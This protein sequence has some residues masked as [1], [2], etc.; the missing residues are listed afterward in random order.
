MNSSNMISIQAKNPGR[1]NFGKRVS[2][3]MDSVIG[4]RKEQQ[5]FAGMVVEDGQVLAVVC[6]GMGGLDGGS[7]ASSSAVKLLLSDYQEQ[8]PASAFSDF[9]CSEAVRLDQCVSMKTDAAGKPLHAGS[10]MVAVILSDGMLDWVSVGD[11][12]IYVVRDGAM[13]PLTRDHNYRRELEEALERGEITRGYFETE[14]STKRADAL[15]NF[16]GMGGIR[17]MDRSIQP[18]ELMDGDMILLCSDGL[19]KRLDEDQIKALLMDNRVSAQVTVRRL[20]RMVMQKALRGQDN[21]TVIVIH[22]GKTQ[23]ET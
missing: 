4:H 22:Y 14:V 2:A 21:T 12:R 23:E 11:S 13:V 1:T 10:T 17:R 7:E 5:D 18:L 3:A 19:Y 16:L 9:L 15:T 20:N 8:R 6:D